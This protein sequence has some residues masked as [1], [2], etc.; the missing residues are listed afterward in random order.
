[1]SFAQTLKTLWRDAPTW[2]YSVIGAGGLTAL[3]LVL[4]LVNSGSNPAP[5]AN[6]NTPPPVKQ[7]IKGGPLTGNVVI[8]PQASATPEIKDR[9][10]RFS[11]RVKAAEREQ[12]AGE[13]CS[14]M[15]KA[16]DILEPG[17]L[18]FIEDSDKAEVKTYVASVEQCREDTQ[19]SDER[20]ANLAA[21]Y[22]DWQPDK[23]AGNVERL[24]T[25]YQ[26]LKDWDESRAYYDEV[27]EQIN[28]GKEAVAKVEKSKQRIAAMQNAAAAQRKSEKQ[29]GLIPLAKVTSKLTNFDIARLSETQ[30]RDYQFGKAAIAQIQASDA[31]LAVLNTAL[32]NAQVNSQGV[33]QMAL[34]DAVAALTP[35]DEIRGNPMHLEK[36]RAA[37]SIAARFALER[38]VSVAKT[39][40]LD[41]LSPE[42]AVQLRNLNAI[43]SENGGINAPT[44]D[45]KNALQTARRATAKLKE[46]DQ[47]IEL[48]KTTA[49]GWMRS[50]SPSQKSAVKTAHD[51]VNDPFNAQRL[52]STDPSIIETIKNAFLVLQAH[53]IGLSP[54]NIGSVPMYI[55]DKSKAA[56]GTG[57]LDLVASEMEAQGY[58]LVK[59]REQS[60]VEV[61]LL[62]LDIDMSNLRIGN[63]RTEG[64]RAQ[65]RFELKWTF[66]D[67]TFL[68]LRGSGRSA[69]SGA[70]E[71]ALANSVADVLNK[72]SEEV[73]GS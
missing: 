3:A 53:E 1:M 6:N 73:Q 46:S 35:F 13:R 19:D 17:D 68:K 28:A 7:P 51:I 33:A 48:A 50:P 41:T 9:L 40:E 49:Q 23:S 66:E 70:R 64:A 18:G 2:R 26:R 16:L 24:A 12:R 22:G 10:L 11:G 25:M 57:Y 14:R 31:R 69:G 21:A 38:L 72:L 15:S 37:K 60:A 32:I 44:P 59:V 39:V 61:Q 52:Q 55:T 45:Q 71:T 56:D 42:T 43:V 36:I 29:G 67:R 47:R 20:F 30:A 62:D 34:V 65:A 8:A 27:I 58:R 63:S 4:G 54:D 5:V